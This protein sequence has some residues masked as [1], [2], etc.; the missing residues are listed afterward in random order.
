MKIQVIVRDD[1]P[2]GTWMGLGG[3]I[4]EASAYNFS[5]L[6]PEKQDDL[7][8]AYYGKNGLDYRLAR[9]SIGSNDFCLKPYEYTKKNNLSD[10]SIGHDKKYVLPMLKTILKTKKLTIVA[11]PWSPPNCLKLA[12]RQNLNGRL[13]PWRYKAFAKYIRKWLESYAKEGVKIDLITPQNEPMA[14]QIWESCVYSYRAQRKLAYKY[15]AKEL[16]NLDTQILL[17]DHNKKDLAKTADKLFNG[18]YVTEYGRSKKIAGLCYHWYD[19][20]FPDQMWHVRQKYPDILMISSEMSCGFSAYDKNDWEKDAALYCWELFND[21]NAGTSAF[22]DWNMLLSW[23]GGPS[24]CQNYVKSPVILNKT[25]DDFIL[26]PIYSA[27]KKFADLFPAGCEIVRCECNSDKIVAIARKTQKG[28]KVIV[29]NISDQ[30][31][32][33]TIQLGSQKKNLRLAKFEMRGGG[34]LF[35]L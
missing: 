8:K 13:K 6:S 20:T 11:S 1:K 22:I 15:L 30:E 34:E 10:F 32:E 19:G 5:K 16:G 12:W 3:A 26:T 33:V 14:S 17:W 24:H 2:L 21:I 23:Q 28:Y 29:K 9:I 27:L 18:K 4:T 31:Q 35:E 7:L 25:G